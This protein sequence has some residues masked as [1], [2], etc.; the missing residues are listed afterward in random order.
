MLKQNK[1]IVSKSLLKRIA[2]IDREIGK[3]RYPN[4]ERLS[5]HLEV[6]E[7]TIQRDI[8][9]MKYEYDAPIEFDKKHLGF[10]YTDER[11]RMNPLTVDASDFLAVAVTEK[12]LEQYKNTPYARYFKTFYQKIANIYEGKLSVNVADIDKILSFYIGPV[13]YVSDDVMNITERALRENIRCKMIYA[14]GHSG[15]ISERLIDIYHLKNHYGDWYIIGHCHKANQV[16]V[17]AMS[18]IK[19]IKL[20]NQHFTVPETFNIESYFADSFGIFESKVT[21]NVKMKIMNESVRY[22]KEKKRHTSEKLTELRDGSII[23]EYKVNEMTEL[24]MWALSLGKDCEILQPAE[25]REAVI[26]ELKSALKHYA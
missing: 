24:L 17:F 8:E 7:K 10:Y 1:S 19:E 16:K 6:S 18:R 3:K 20:T 22:V 15:T 14:T 26:S 9:F 4:K 23:L 5:K 2:V 21:Y 12:V 13:R 11:F 25:L